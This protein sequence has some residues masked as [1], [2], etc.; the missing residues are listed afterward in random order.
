MGASPPHDHPHVFIDMGA[1]NQILCPY[2][3]TVFL[4][5]SMMGANEANP[6]KCLVT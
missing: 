2:C 6:I 1:R 3:A 5:D 4:Y